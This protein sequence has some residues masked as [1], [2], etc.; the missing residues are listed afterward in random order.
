MIVIVL[1][2][3][4]VARL[5]PSLLLLLSLRCSMAGKAAVCLALQVSGPALPVSA[6]AVLLV[7][8]TMVC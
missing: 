6:S 5:S 7:L 8:S 4:I 2:A 1:V 3:E